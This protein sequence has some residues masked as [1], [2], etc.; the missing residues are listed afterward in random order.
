ME[1]ALDFL[2]VAAAASQVALALLVILAVDAGAV[3]RRAEP[4]IDLVEV[5]E[6]NDPELFVLVQEVEHGQEVLRLLALCDGV[7][8][9]GE[10]I[11]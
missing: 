2:S 4:V 3:L 9:E 11:H 6:Q 10:D 5:D 8:V 7:S 1:E